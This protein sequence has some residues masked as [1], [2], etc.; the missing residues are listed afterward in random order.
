MSIADHVER[1]LVSESHDKTGH[2]AELQAFEKSVLHNYQTIDG[3]IPKEG[4]QHDWNDKIQVSSFAYLIYSK[5]KLDS[6][7]QVLVL[8]LGK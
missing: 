6:D 2:T 7:F 8:F 1:K 5:N 4:H 3:P